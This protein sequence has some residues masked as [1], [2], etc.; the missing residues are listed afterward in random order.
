MFSVSGDQRFTTLKMTLGPSRTDTVR[1]DS[2]LTPH[3]TRPLTGP[4]TLLE[5]EGVKKYSIDVGARGP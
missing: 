5:D 2:P 4:S 1:K 3:L